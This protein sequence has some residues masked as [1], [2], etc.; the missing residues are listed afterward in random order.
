MRTVGARFGSAYPATCTRSPGVRLPTTTSPDKHRGRAQNPPLRAPTPCAI[1]T[2]RWVSTNG[3][4]LTPVTVRARHA[5]PLHFPDGKIGVREW[6]RPSPRAIGR[7]QDAGATTQPGRVENPPLPGTHHSP[8]AIR[9]SP[10]AI[11]YSPFAIRRFFP[12]AIR[13]SR[14]LTHPCSPTKM[15]V[16]QRMR[17]CLRTE[18]RVWNLLRQPRHVAAGRVENPPLP[19]SHH[20]AFTIHHSLFAIRHSLFFSIRHSQ[21]AIRRVFPLLAVFHCG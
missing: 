13:Y 4:W 8:F 3:G 5:V 15:G 7:G 19:G 10:F 17:G 20:S 1:G 14:F 21:F 16:Q 18:A 9:H 12:F 11:R 6:S 2:V